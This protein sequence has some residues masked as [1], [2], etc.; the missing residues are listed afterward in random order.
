VIK[1]TSDR[2]PPKLTDKKVDLFIKALRVGHYVDRAARLAGLAPSTVYRWLEEGEAEQQR[3]DAEEE[4]T[5]RGQAYLKI[6]NEIIKAKEEA[7][8]R[9]LATIQKAFPKSWQAAA[10]YLERTD[11]RHYGRLTQ[12]TGKDQGPL[13]VNVTVDEVEKVL[14]TLLDSADDGDEEST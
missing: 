13:A 14:K 5:E 4:I 6:A 7:S 12:V 8:H 2:K 3:I 1:N 10:W 9:A 11:Q